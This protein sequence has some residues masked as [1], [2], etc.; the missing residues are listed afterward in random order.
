MEQITKEFKAEF[1]GVVVKANRIARK[2]GYGHA[3]A[4]EIGAEDK[5][6]SHTRF[7]YRKYTTGEYGKWIGEKA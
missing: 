7:G 4:V 1:P 3:T 6:I 5:V 2:N